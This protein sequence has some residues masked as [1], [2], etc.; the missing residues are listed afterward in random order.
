MPPTVQRILETALYVDD[1]ARA[2]AFY[3]DVMGLK[4][5]IGDQRFCALNVSERSVLLLFLRGATLQPTE[6]PGGI[7]PPHDGSGPLHYA[8]AIEA[9]DL[10]RWEQHLSRLQIAI[11]S[12]TNWPAGGKSIYF[13]DPDGNLL[14][15]ATPGVWPIY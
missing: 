6:I 11:E 5:M 4:A 14:E 7:I 2:R 1:V 9:E 15:L 3:E 8:F 10:D 13:R 12:R